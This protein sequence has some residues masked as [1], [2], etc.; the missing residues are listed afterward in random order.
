[1]TSVRVRLVDLDDAD[2]VGDQHPHQAGRVG[3]G[4]LHADPIDLPCGRSQSTSR[5]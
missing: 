1:M 5:A 3:A 2:P 4:R